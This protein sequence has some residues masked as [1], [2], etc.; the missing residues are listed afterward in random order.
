MT[1]RRRRLPWP[2]LAAAATLA[3]HLAVALAFP[4]PGIFYKYGAAADLYVAG[5]LPAERLIDFSPLYFHLAVLAKRLSGRP[6]LVLQGFQMVLVAVAAGL[7]A[8]LLARRFKTPLAVATL[9]AFAVDR[10]L[11][12]YERILEPEAVLLFAILGWLFFVE[13][14]AEGRTG[15]A[16]A[17]G[18]FA[19][20]SLFVRPTFLPAYL[21]VA[22]YWRLHDRRRRLA[23]RFAVGVVL[24]LLALALR[25]ASITG[26]PRTPAMNPGTVFYE[27]TNP[28]SRGT[29]AVYPALVLDRVGDDVSDPDPAHGLYRTVARADAGEELSVTE[30][31][32]YWSGVA[33]GYVRAQPGRYARLLLEKLGRVFH[34]YRW[35][36]IDVAWLYDRTLKVPA[37]P[38]GLVA[39]LGLLGLAFEAR[40]LETSLPFYLVAGVQLAVMLVFYVSA[41]QRLVLL[42]A[43]YY[44]AAAA[45]ESMSSERRRL[46]LGAPL[47]VLLALAL[48][49]PN[50]LVR[51]DVYRRSGKAAGKAAFGRLRGL[52]GDAG[53]GV[54]AHTEA[55]LDALAWTP[56]VEWTPP[57]F[58]QDDRG[59]DE[60]M[61]ERLA[62]E[63]D[64]SVPRVFDRA[65]VFQRAGWHDRAETLLEEL[66]EA[67]AEV[68]R[69]AEEASDPRFLLARTMERTGRA[70]RARSLLEEALARS[71]GDPFAAAELYVLTGEPRYEEALRS[72]TSPLDADFFLAKAFF[73]QGRSRDAAALFEKLVRRLPRWRTGRIYLAAALAAQG[74]I[75]EGAEQYLE[76]K[77]QAPDPL[78]LS[79]QISELFRRWADLH[80]QDVRKQLFA[81]RVLHE[82]G[83]L[84]DAMTVLERVPP[85]TPY[86]VAVAE[87]LGSVR[88]SLAE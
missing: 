54:A 42:P 21:V 65:I 13:G 63:D 28:L 36:D 17:A 1:G 68:Y 14:A 19:A 64:A 70:D 83:R 31:N 3:V 9:A 69:G 38:F 51:D 88:R 27:G 5:R 34:A 77:R 84:H 15:A 61:A 32:A 39:A 23:G 11:L 55:A 8:T 4:L 46:L 81:A 2:L 53:E 16:W 52:T 59:L 73:F 44:F 79:R 37:V 74:R 18:G 43:L 41:R 71:P 24:A 35:H 56:W 76:A 45:L 29:S 7:F 75:D 26:D 57:F 12:V 40:R 66:I 67:G 47:A 25:S 85:G 50:D 49:L 33:L 72:G 62:T 48:S 60:Q 30:V 78:Y 86:D 22:I 87:E 80:P 10:H 82:N 20:V 6:E 58:P